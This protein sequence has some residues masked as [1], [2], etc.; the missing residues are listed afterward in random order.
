MVIV[1]NGISVKVTVTRPK[2]ETAE[3][4]RAR[5]QAV[6]KDRQERRKD[7]KSTKEMFSSERKQQNKVMSTREKPGVRSL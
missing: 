7:K 2:Q 1:S 5:K 4:K 6:K 3:E